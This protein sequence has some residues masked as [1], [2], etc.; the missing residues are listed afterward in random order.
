MSGL[1][2]ED[3]LPEGITT[4]EDFS[5][6]FIENPADRW[7]AVRA[8]VE[9]DR[10]DVFNRL[11]E[12]LEGTDLEVKV[13]DMISRVVIYNWP[14]RMG[15]YSTVLE[16]VPAWRIENMRFMFDEVS[17]EAIKYQVAILHGLT[18]LPIDCYR[19]IADVFRTEPVPRF[20]L[21]AKKD[22]KNRLATRRLFEKANWCRRESSFQYVGLLTSLSHADVIAWFGYTPLF[23]LMLQAE[24]FRTATGIPSYLLYTILGYIEPALQHCTPPVK[25]RSHMVYR[26]GFSI[27]KN[28][29]SASRFAWLAKC[30]KK[31]VPVEI[32]NSFCAVGDAMLV[33]PRE[34]KAAVA[35]AFGNASLDHPRHKSTRLLGDLAHS[36]EKLPDEPYWLRGVVG[37]G[38]G[39]SA[40]TP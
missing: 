7:N 13:K 2:I 35:I 15:D 29:T 33:G 6:W 24:A 21:L 1:Q 30:L 17:L 18:T 36:F 10:D 5:G 23:T 27:V 38:A 8:L 26:A 32:H 37:A 9:H 19:H 34:A 31:E 39:T 20:P 28:I 12:T 40:A 3:I 22:K 4:Y 14:N 25:L 11:L 16:S